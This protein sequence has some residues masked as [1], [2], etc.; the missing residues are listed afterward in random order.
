MDQILQGYLGV[1]IGSA[2]AKDDKDL[3]SLL[4][5]YA[6]EDTKGSK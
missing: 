1:D 6:E 2:E 3:E 5:D 4:M